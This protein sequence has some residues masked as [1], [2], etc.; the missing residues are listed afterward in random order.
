M[1][2]IQVAIPTYNRSDLLEKLLSTIPHDVKV[3]VSDNGSYTDEKLK[4]KYTNATFISSPNVLGVFSNWNVAA[5]NATSEWVLI[6]SDDDLFY[7]NTFNVIDLYIKKYPNVDMLV[8]G[9]DTID[10]YE[11][12]KEGW[13]VKKEVLLE[14]PM[15]FNLFKYGVDARMPAVVFKRSMLQEMEYFDENFKLTSGDSDLIQRVLLK[16][17]VA[18]IPEKIAAYRVWNGALTHQKIATKLWLTEIDL[19]QSKIKVLGENAFKEKGLNTLNF[20]SIKDEVYAQNLL[21]GLKKI[22]NSDG[23]LACLR[24]IIENRY[25]FMAQFK[26]QIIIL[27]TI[28]LG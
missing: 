21:A 6:P 2:N 22:R 17:N 28:L 23:F 11:V 7:H 19:W 25:P 5:K 12:K 4:T 15:G 26:T 13:S 9:H 14:C 10:E 20:K 1:R 3:S 8:F 27:K 16:G 24:F 18:V